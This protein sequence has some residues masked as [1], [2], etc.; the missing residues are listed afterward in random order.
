MDDDDSPLHSFAA[1]ASKLLPPPPSKGGRGASVDRDLNRFGKDLNQFS[2]R[3]E[4]ASSQQPTSTFKSRFLPKHRKSVNLSPSPERDFKDFDIKA[5]MSRKNGEING[6]NTRGSSVN[7][8]SSAGSSNSSSNSSGYYSYSNEGGM[9]KFTI[10][11]PPVP[12]DKV[13]EKKWRMGERRNDRRSVEPSDLMR[14]SY[15]KS[16]EPR[17]IGDKTNFTSNLKDYKG[18]STRRSLESSEDILRSSYSTSRRSLEPSDDIL[19]RSRYGSKNDYSLN[20]EAFSRRSVGPVERSNYLNRRSLEPS[21]DLLRS[22]YGSSLRD[23]KPRSDDFLRSSYGSSLREPKPSNNNSKCSSDRSYAQNLR[24]SIAPSKKK[25]NLSVSIKEFMKRTDPNSDL[26]ASERRPARATSVARDDYFTRRAPSLAPDR[27]DRSARAQS[28]A[29]DTPYR[30][31]NNYTSFRDNEPSLMTS[32]YSR[33]NSVMDYDR[34]Y[35]DNDLSY[36]YAPPMS[37]Y[38]IKEPSYVSRPNTVNK[39]FL[40]LEDECN[41][42]LGGKVGAPGR[43]SNGRMSSVLRDDQS[44]DEDTLDDIS[45]D[46]VVAIRYSPNLDSIFCVNE[47]SEIIGLRSK[48]PIDRGVIHERKEICLFLSFQVDFSKFRCRRFLTLSRPLLQPLKAVKLSL[49]C[50]CSETNSKAFFA[51]TVLKF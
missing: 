32:R 31:N 7:R 49:V 43:G 37:R 20:R 36:S 17:E 42:I 8:S 29:L 47:R 18:L 45:G 38:G 15:R 4:R 35:R 24:A 34:S 10:N 50:F 25:E 41:W 39:K 21:D 28:V 33:E 51:L 23:T 13:L 12:E 9:L 14:S 5:Y 27:Y 22:S 46:E 6:T 19:L 26:S 3:F 40:T 11:E 30:R 48:P 44:D 1:P 2:S 16:I